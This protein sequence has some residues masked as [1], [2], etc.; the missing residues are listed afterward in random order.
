MAEEG[1]HL[2]GSFWSSERGTFRRNRKYCF[3][4]GEEWGTVHMEL[5]IP[6]KEQRLQNI[7][8]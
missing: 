2:L 7:N 6:T 4:W 3:I 1:E 8:R 5:I